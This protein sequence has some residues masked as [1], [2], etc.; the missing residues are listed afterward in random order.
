MAG[1][2]CINLSLYSL[3]SH[4]ELSYLPGFILTGFAVSARKH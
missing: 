1:H 4:Y 3:S 2:C